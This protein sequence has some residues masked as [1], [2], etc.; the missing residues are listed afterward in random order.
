[1]FSFLPLPYSKILKLY[2]LLQVW[3]TQRVVSKVCYNELYGTDR[4]IS[5]RVRRP[6]NRRHATLLLHPV[7]PAGLLPIEATEATKASLI[8][9]GLGHQHYADLLP[10]DGQRSVLEQCHTRDD[11]EFVNFLWFSFKHSAVV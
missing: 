1:M 6:R 8:S 7:F 10:A 2:Y 4:A 9:Q 5:N 3:A 11:W